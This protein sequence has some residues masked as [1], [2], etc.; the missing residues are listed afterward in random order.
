VSKRNV[1]QVLRGYEAL[2]RRD[3]EAALVGLSPD[4]VW[5][6]P[7]ALPEG[8]REFHGHE[9]VMEF[10]RMWHETFE[11]FRAEIEETTDAGDDV[12]V[13]VMVMVMVR[14][15]GRHKD[16]GAEVV[17]QSFPHVWTMRDGE[18]VR[19]EMYTNRATALGALGLSEERSG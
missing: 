15:H 13:M 3:I 19:M 16:S 12:M 7:E 1:E 10:W 6:A 14:L 5:L 8:E 11:E 17:T 18:V 4:I 9:G 2:N